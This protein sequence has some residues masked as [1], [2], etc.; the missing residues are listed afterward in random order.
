[1]RR[2]LP[3]TRGRAY[4]RGRGAR[5]VCARSLLLAAPVNRARARQVDGTAAT[6]DNILS[7]LVGCDEPGSKVLPHDISCYYDKT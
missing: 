6:P 7:I 3:V 1:M 5:H 2:A 4:A